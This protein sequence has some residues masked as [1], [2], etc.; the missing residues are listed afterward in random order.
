MDTSEKMVRSVYYDVNT[1]TYAKRKDRKIKRKKPLR[2]FDDRETKHDSKKSAVQN[3]EFRVI[4]EELTGHLT[5]EI[6]LRKAKK[7]YQEIK[8]ILGPVVSKIELVGS[9]SRLHPTVNDLDIVAVPK[10]KDVKE[11]LEKKGISAESGAEKVVNF[12]YKGVMVNLW[13]TPKESFGATVLHFSAGKGIIQI[14]QLAIQKGLKLNRYGL[15]RGDTKIAGEDYNEILKILGTETKFSKLK[16][17]EKVIEN[18]EEP[19]RFKV[20]GQF[21]RDTPMYWRFRQIDPK[22]FDQG[23]FKLIKGSTGN[24]RVIGKINGKWKVQSILIGKD[25]LNKKEI[26][27]YLKLVEK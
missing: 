21:P 9:A 7:L 8:K 15:F 23:S 11:Y 16:I 27:E 18:S 10:S 1:N 2:N 26:D 22:K 12:N 5:E 17:L 13:L 24:A 6:E 25:K 14:K 20:E 19:E 4:K 3:A